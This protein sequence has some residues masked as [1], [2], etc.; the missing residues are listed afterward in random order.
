[1]GTRRGSSPISLQDV[2]SAESESVNLNMAI[3]SR[4]AFFSLHGS[5]SSL[6]NLDQLLLTIYSIPTHS[7]IPCPRNL[8][9]DRPGDSLSIKHAHPVAFKL[10][11]VVDHLREEADNTQT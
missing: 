9:A 10:A 7:K 8:R 11:L 5:I 1:M 6:P 2:L 3:S 4:Y